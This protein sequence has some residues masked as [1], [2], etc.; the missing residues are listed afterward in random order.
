V[1]LSNETYLPAFLPSSVAG[2][3]VGK[4]LLGWN[5]IQRA[6]MAAF[7]F[8]RLSSAAA[9][10]ALQQS[11][12]YACALLRSSGKRAVVQNTWT[13]TT[14]GGSLITAAAVAVAAIHSSAC[15]AASPATKDVSM[16]SSFS[17]SHMYVSSAVLSFCH[18]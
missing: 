8:L 18:C 15:L 13:T 7:G 17:S 14:G 4:A 9:S 16:T 10:T 11:S 5:P 12:R 6:L 1:P 3:L 2:F